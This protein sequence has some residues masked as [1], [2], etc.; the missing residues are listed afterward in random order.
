[1]DKHLKMP[2]IV[3]TKNL[4]KLHNKLNMQKSSIAIVS[5]KDEPLFVKFERLGGESM[6]QY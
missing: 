4:E 5:K 3:A 1:M 2:K 6:T